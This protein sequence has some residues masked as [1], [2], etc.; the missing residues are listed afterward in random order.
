[1]QSPVFLLVLEVGEEEAC[2]TDPGSSVVLGQ[3]ARGEGF[4][5]TIVVPS[6]SAELSLSS[7]LP[8]FRKQALCSALTPR[9]ECQAWM[10]LAF[11]I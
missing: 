8:V 4:S 9:M 3:S 7:P 10:G 11:G 1:M 6:P 5:A 2:F